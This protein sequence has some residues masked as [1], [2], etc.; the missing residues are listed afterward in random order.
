MKRTLEEKYK[1]NKARTDD[2]FSF[3]YC[4]GAD[5]YKDYAKADSK[6]RKTIRD[7]IDTAK[8]SARGGDSL[9]KGIMCGYKDA[10]DERKA[11]QKR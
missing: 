9:C 6:Y 2:N 7:L 1:Y 8:I 5:I 11:K 3:G 4:Y 10:A